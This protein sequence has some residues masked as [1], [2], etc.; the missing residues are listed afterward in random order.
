MTRLWAVRFR[1]GS[2][3][4]IEQGGDCLES[5][6]FDEESGESGI[7][8]GLSRLLM[9]GAGDG[10]DPRRDARVRQD[11]APDVDAGRPSRQAESSRTRLG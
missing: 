5:H 10:D 2:A 6:G 8:A 11:G 7:A 4:A 9:T 1:R 3:P